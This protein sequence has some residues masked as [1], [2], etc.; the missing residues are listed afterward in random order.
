VGALSE[1]ARVLGEFD[2]DGPDPQ[3]PL[4]AAVEVA[5]YRITLEAMTNVVRH[6]DARQA[7]VRIDIRDAVHIEVTDDGSGLPAVQRPGVG[8]A[9][10]RERAVELGGAFTVERAEPSGTIVRASIPLEPT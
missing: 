6:A 8:I 5:A 1:Q 9:S 10:M 4:P 3:P 2:V 7:R